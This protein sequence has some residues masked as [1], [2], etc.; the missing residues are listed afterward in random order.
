MFNFPSSTTILLPGNAFFSPCI[1][2]SLYLYIYLLV[3][4]FIVNVPVGGNPNCS[5]QAEEDNH[6][7]II[8]RKK[9]ERGR[10]GSAME[11]F[12]KYKKEEKKKKK[13]RGGKRGRPSESKRLKV[14]K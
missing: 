14:K 8:V 3:C 9:T 10:E 5:S 6:C 2:L 7:E 11:R 13:T 12:K 1:Y 4:L